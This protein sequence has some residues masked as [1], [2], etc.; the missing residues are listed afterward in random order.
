MY[1]CGCRGSVRSS[2]LDHE[3]TLSIKERSLASADLESIFPSLGNQ[4]FG[5]SLE[6]SLGKNSGVL[7]ACISEAPLIGGATKAF[8]WRLQP[9]LTVSFEISNYALKRR[10]HWSQNQK[11]ITHEKSLSVWAVFSLCSHNFKMQFLEPC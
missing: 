7:S 9:S 3:V 10:H 1:K 8:L 2:H 6:R 4:D 11:P 5:K